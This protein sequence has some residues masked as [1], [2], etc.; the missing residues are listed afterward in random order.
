[1]T[2]DWTV[3]R[4]EPDDRDAVWWVHDRS[5]RE[6]AMDYSPEYNRYLRHVEREFIRR[7]G[8]F[9]VATI[10]DPD[11]EEILD[12]TN[13]L[14]AI[15]GF[16]PLTD[17][18]DPE[19]PIWQALEGRVESTARIR[20]VAVLPE[21]QSRGI[22]TALVTELESR[23]A[24]DFARVVLTTVADMHATRGFYESLGYEQVETNEQGTGYVWYD[25]DI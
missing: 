4:Y 21:F 1:M 2:V 13:G 18:D 14:V 10:D 7:G 3:R 23:A 24:K 12:R 6:S 22:G 19:S 15:G 20:S 9:L 5:L 16:Q 25:K 17:S 11:Q 8:E